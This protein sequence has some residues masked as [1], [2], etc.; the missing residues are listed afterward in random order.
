MSFEKVQA[1][2]DDTQGRRSLKPTGE[3]DSDSECDEVLIAVGQEN[4]FPWIERDS[5]IAFDEWGMPVLDKTTLQSIDPARLFRRRCGAWPE[6]H[7]LGGRAR[8]RCRDFDRQAA[9]RRRRAR[10]PCSRRDAAVAEDGHPRVELRQRDRQRRA[11]QGALAR[12][13]PGRCATS[14]SKSS[15]ASTPA[16]AWKEAQRCLN[17]DVQT[18]FTRAAVHRVRRVRRHLPDRLHHLHANG[19]GSRLRTRLTRAC[20][21]PRPGLYVAEAL[22]TGRVM[23]KDE[24]VCLHCG[25]CA[26]RCPTGAWDMQKFLL[27]MRTPDG[28]AAVSSARPHDDASRAA[29]AAVND[30]VV[31]FANVNGSG[32]ASANELFARSILRMGVPVT[33]RNIFPSNI[34][35]LPTWYEVRVSEQ[36]YLGRRGGVD[37][38]VAMN[39]QTWD[40]GSGGDRAWRLPALRQ[41]QA[42][43]R[44]R[45]SA[46][47]ST[48]I[49]VP[50]TDICGREVHRSTR[51]PAAEEHHVR[52]RAG[53]AARHRA[54][55]DRAAARRAVQGQGQAAQA[56]PRRVHDRA[57]PRPR[58]PGR[59]RSALR[60]ERRDSGRRPHLH[61]RQRRRG[62]RL[63]LRRR[64]GLRVVS[65]HAVVVAGRGV[66]EV[67]H[68][69]LACRCRRPAGT[70][71]RSCR[72]RTRSRR[73]ASSSA[74]A[75]TA[76]ARSPRR[77]ARA[78]R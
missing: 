46:P 13:Q 7:H 63:R 42:D 23:V 75:G 12:R 33:P 51:A 17:C 77:R 69:S 60:I 44:R 27:D 22:K 41:H 47:T 9:A 21:E 73:S 49:G 36:G 39:P 78:S 58:A 25:L 55:R 68:A 74:P 14:R 57:A 40:A 67:L 34:Q 53:G 45:S 37:L 11:L 52:R 62:A 72:P 38:M 29:S 76:R 70:S 26:E 8:P 5:G 28:A 20:A 15:S 24:D 16:T 50:L 43:C 3:P 19:R 10:A 66:P 6:E 18:V 59:G 1:Q 71:S 30:F 32:S 64:D 4:A 2:Y 54:R 31:K 65:D 35:G 48:L 56:E 61:R